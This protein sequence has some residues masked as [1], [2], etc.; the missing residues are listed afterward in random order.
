MATTKLWTA[1]EVERLPDDE[2]RYALIKGVLFRMP[3]PMARHGR[4][5]NNAGRHIGNFVAEHN[6]GVVYNQSGFI[7]ERHP[8]VLLEP[9]LAFVQTARVPA[10]ETTYPVLAPDL[11]VEVVSPSQ[12][13]PAIEDKVAIYLAAG[14]RLVWAIDPVRRSVH[15][16][17]FD[18]SNQFLTEDDV[19]DGEDVLPGFQLPIAQLFV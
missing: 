15:I 17:R 7:L 4:I 3:P 11:V 13:G 1:E 6:V 5:T 9:D 19:L 18:G 12:S 14:V 16:H 10:D 8:D 2:F